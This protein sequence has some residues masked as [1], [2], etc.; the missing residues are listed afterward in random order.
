MKNRLLVSVNYCSDLLNLLK[1]RSSYLTTS[2][3][4]FFAFDITRKVSQI[5]VGK[6]GAVTEFC[7][8]MKL[9]SVVLCSLYFRHPVEQLKEQLSFCIG[10][11]FVSIV[12]REGFMSFSL[13]TKIRK[14][15]CLAAQNGVCSSDDLETPWKTS[16]K[17]GAIYV[18]GC[19]QPLSDRS[20]ISFTVRALQ[21]YSFQTTLLNIDDSLRQKRVSHGGTVAACLSTGFCKSVVCARRNTYS[22][23]VR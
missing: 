1:N 19:I 4:I 15:A 13:H 2:F 9:S 23:G 22:R 10:K 11:Q 17:G 18:V 5:C 6:D 14:R 21:F 20:Q 16:N 7:S 3:T 8:K 12:G